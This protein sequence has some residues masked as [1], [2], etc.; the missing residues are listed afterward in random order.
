MASVMPSFLRKAIRAVAVPALDVLL[1]GR[2]DDARLSAQPEPLE[3]PA[4]AIGQ[5]AV[6]VEVDRIAGGGLAFHPLTGDGDGGAAA[7]KLALAFGEDITAAKIADDL[8]EYVRKTP[9]PGGISWRLDVQAR[10]VGYSTSQPRRATS[11]GV[12]TGGRVFDWFH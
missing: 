3:G 6:C 12:T 7:G 1:E 11:G 5:S 9:R 10:P 2:L 8:A 4:E